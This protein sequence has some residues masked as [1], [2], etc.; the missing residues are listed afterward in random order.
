MYNLRLKSNHA[1]V[2]V[3]QTVGATVGARRALQWVGFY[4]FN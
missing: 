4:L 1:A 2:L 3:S